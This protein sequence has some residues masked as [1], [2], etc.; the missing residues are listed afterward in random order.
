MCNS[1]K[2]DL[3]RTGLIFVLGLII[4][5]DHMPMHPNFQVPLEVGFSSATSC[6]LDRQ[7]CKECNST[8]RAWTLGAPVNDR[9]KFKPP[10]W[11]G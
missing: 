1:L 3:F 5:S 8:E 6:F 11:D 9:L 2:L 10:V 4:E 7:F